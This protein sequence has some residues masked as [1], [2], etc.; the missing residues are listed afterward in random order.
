MKKSNKIPIDDM[1]ADSDWL[2]DEDEHPGP[3]RHLCV[4]GQEIVL[5]Q[6]KKELLRHTLP[7]R[8][9]DREIFAIMSAWRDSG[10]DAVRKVLET[11]EEGGH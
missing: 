7:R 6:D 1:L 9:H 8:I 4:D 5:S 10:L 11:T 2:F 3:C